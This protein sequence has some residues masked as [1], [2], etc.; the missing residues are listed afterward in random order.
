MDRRLTLTSRHHMLC[1]VPQILDAAQGEEK[2]EKGPRS[3]E[4]RKV[5]VTGTPESQ[6][7]V[8]WLLSDIVTQSSLSDRLVFSFKILGK[9]VT[10]DSVL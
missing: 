2:R 10:K 6:W 1:S 4:Q 9:I 3:E 7:K 8:R 5:I